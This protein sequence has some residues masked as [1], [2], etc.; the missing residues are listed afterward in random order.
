MDELDIC[1]HCG[2]AGIFVSARSYYSRGWPA[3]C[4]ECGGLSYDRPH[5]MSRFFEFLLEYIRPLLLLGFVVAPWWL[6]GAILAVVGISVFL[7]VRVQRRRKGASRFNPIT[8]EKSRMSRRV[9]LSMV[10]AAFVFAI[11]FALFMASRP[12]RPSAPLKIK[13]HWPVRSAVIFP[14]EFSVETGVVS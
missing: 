5:G 6:E 13:W 10:L 8:P 1:P 9:T 11:L 2:K 4:R 14:S 3:V 12:V 7:I